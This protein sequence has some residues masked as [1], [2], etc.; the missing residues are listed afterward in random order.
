MLHFENEGV[1]VT[2][3]IDQ[4][5]QYRK[6]S[7]WLK[8][9]PL[10]NH[11]QAYIIVPILCSQMHTGCIYFPLQTVNFI[12]ASIIPVFYIPKPKTVPNFKWSLNTVWI[13]DWK[14]EYHT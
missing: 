1:V 13:I 2:V 12:N 9:P 4:G 8:T 7:I 3:G 6:L 11:W 5:K 14:N 10:Y